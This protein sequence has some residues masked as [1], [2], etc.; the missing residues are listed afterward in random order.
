MLSEKKPKIQNLVRIFIK[1]QTQL[2][3]HSWRID[4]LTIGSGPKPRICILKLILQMVLLDKLQAEKGER[5][6]GGYFP[7]A[8]GRIASNVCITTFWPE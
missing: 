2:L 1:G 3:A 8:L 7:L 5:G 6:R 4:F